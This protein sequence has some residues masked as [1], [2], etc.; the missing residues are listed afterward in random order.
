MF[1]KKKHLWILLFGSLIGLNETLIGSFNIPYRSVILSS[2]TLAI[3]SIARSQI[4]KSGTSLLIIVIAI[5]YKINSIGVHS[6]TTN[7]LL[8]GPTALLILGIGYE[9]FASLIIAKNTFKYLNYILA[10]GFTSIVAFSIFAV[11][12]TYILG[13]WDTSRLSEYIFVKASL[14]VIASSVIS[15]LAL[16]T[17]S[18]F[19]NVNVARLNPYVIQGLLGSTIIALWIFGYFI[20]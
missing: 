3:L 11:M 7:V 9:V 19:K 16:Y 6:C 18:F 13:A 14:T 17:V 8:C 20:I 15:I 5:L 10:C 12:N 4:P 1:I 2:I